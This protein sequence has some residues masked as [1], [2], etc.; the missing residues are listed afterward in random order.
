MNKT[1]QY[2][3]MADILQDIKWKIKTFSLF[4]YVGWTKNDEKKDLKGKTPGQ[5]PQDVF[6]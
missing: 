5:K 4:N 6:S 1:E 2:R 3:D